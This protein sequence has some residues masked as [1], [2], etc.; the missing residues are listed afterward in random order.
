MC[1]IRAKLNTSVLQLSWC[2]SEPSRWPVLSPGM[3]TLV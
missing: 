3:H 2:G 1:L